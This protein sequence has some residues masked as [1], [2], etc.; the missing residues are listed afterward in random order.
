MGR[1]PVLAVSS[2]QGPPAGDPTVAQGAGRGVSQP[3]SEQMTSLPC[4][5]L[6]PKAGGR[7]PPWRQIRGLSSL[8]KEK[9]HDPFSSVGGICL[10]R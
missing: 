7:S 6:V 9:S 2:A 8:S 5:L 1:H 4:V 10:R 3:H